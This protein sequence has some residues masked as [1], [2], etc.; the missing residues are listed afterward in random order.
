[1]LSKMLGGCKC[2]QA[3]RK[4]GQKGTKLERQRH[5]GS[6]WHLQPV[7]ANRDSP[8]SCSGG[9]GLVGHFFDLLVLHAVVAKS[10]RSGVSAEGDAQPSVHCL[11]RLLVHIVVEIH[12]GDFLPHVFQVPQSA[13]CSR[14][15]RRES[16]ES[17]L[18]SFEMVIFSAISSVM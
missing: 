18:E 17:S 4:K 16:S 15:S 8:L 11:N 1:M 6:V 13:I 12:T 3:F 10:L 9:L 5:L 14:S 2:R 7:V